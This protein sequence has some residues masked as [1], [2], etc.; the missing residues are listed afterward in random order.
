[1]SAVTAGLIALAVA[2]TA[3][4]AASL[5]SRHGRPPVPPQ[6]GPNRILFPFVAQ[7]LAPRALDA[8]LRLAG[9]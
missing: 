6:M 7:G 3:A 8:A 1:M 5:I 4:L 2:L 9:A